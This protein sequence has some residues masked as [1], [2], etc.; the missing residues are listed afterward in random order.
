[1]ALVGVCGGEDVC[2]LTSAKIAMSVFPRSCCTYSIWSCAS[3]MWLWMRSFLAEASS[4]R[5]RRRSSVHV[6]TKRGVSTGSTRRSCAGS[7]ETM[8]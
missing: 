5:L 2:S 1:M 6:G 3:A 8:P 7:L 4:P